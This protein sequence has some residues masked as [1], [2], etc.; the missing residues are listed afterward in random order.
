MPAQLILHFLGYYD[1]IPMLGPSVGTR[2]FHE[3]WSFFSSIQVPGTRSFG[4]SIGI[5]DEN[6][7]VVGATQTIGTSSGFG[8]GDTGDTET[9]EGEQGE[10][11][12]GERAGKDFLSSIPKIIFLQNY[13]ILC[14][15]HLCNDTYQ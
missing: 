12:E 9:G 5:N 11:G 1:L 8:S 6:Y 15:Y 13:F 10:Q 14:S 4:S 7:I 3:D 2:L